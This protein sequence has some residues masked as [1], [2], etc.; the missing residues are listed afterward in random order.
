MPMTPVEAFVHGESGENTSRASLARGA[1]QSKLLELRKHSG[2]FGDLGKHL[3]IL[4]ELVEK[5]VFLSPQPLGTLGSQGLSETA[6][7]R[8]SSSLNLRKP[9]GGLSPRSD[10]RPPSPNLARDSRILG[11]ASVLEAAAA[12]CDGNVGVNR[13]VTSTAFIGKTPRPDIHKVASTGR[14]AM[15]KDTTSCNLAD[16]DDFIRSNIL[17]AAFVSSNHF[18]SCS[19]TQNRPVVDPCPQTQ[20]IQ[21]PSFVAFHNEDGQVENVQSAHRTFLVD[22]GNDGDDLIIE[23]IQISDAP[24]RTDDDA[25]NTLAQGKLSQIRRNSTTHLSEM[26]TTLQQSVFSNGRDNV[27]RSRD[28]IGK[29]LYHTRFEVGLACM[30]IANA[31][32]LGL[33]ADEAIRDHEPTYAY[34]VI[35]KCFSCVFFIE[36]L[37]RVHCERLF[38]FNWSNPNLTWNALDSIL[39]LAAVF[40]EVLH[41]S[42]YAESAVDVRVV[43]ML[44]LLRVVRM[45]RTAKLV[46]YF[47][48]LRVMI[49]GIMRSCGSLLWALMLLAMLMYLTAVLIVEMLCT[50]TVAKESDVT[51]AMFGSVTTTLYTLYLSVLGGIDWGDA[52]DPLFTVDFFLGCAFSLY[53]SFSVLCVL[54][55]ITGVFVEN[56]NRVTAQSHEEELLDEL[57]M[58]NRYIG[59]AKEFIAENQVIGRI[60][61]DQFEN[62]IGKVDFEAIL[63]KLD[64]LLEPKHARSLFNMLDFDQTGS[65]Q[66]DE[67]LNRLDRIHGV[68]KG[69]D[70]QRLAHSADLLHE[71]INCLA[72]SRVPAPSIKRLLM[73]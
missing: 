57:S 17:P 22:N 3:R 72:N 38:L 28:R 71:K 40:E 32:L 11:L 29:V 27:P 54:N 46:R 73:D 60:N 35:S 10:P 23:D 13:G 51:M 7:T 53:V 33:Q 68:A 30:V 21:H 5:E 64:V 19:R 9:T 63:R 48:D 62:L 20:T 61:E 36:L 43:R 45:L 56:A 26:I 41:V 8:C 58:R 55:I 24:C 49:L 37:L 1:E 6:A 66:V 70:I 65:I 50:S 59:E 39:V 2:L 18:A 31:L 25:A 4:G 52:A 12:V 44:R 14:K 47:Q 16:G 67:L 34:Y 69:I 15:L 42:T